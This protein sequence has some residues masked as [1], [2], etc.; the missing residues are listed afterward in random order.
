MTDI[1]I[2]IAFA[3]T[4][5]LQTFSKV[6][7]QVKHIMV[8]KVPCSRERDKIDGYKFMKLI[9]LLVIFFT[10]KGNSQQPFIRFS[11]IIGHNAKDRKGSLKKYTFSEVRKMLH[12][13]CKS[14]LLH[15]EFK[16]DTLYMLES[17]DIEDQTYYG[18]IWNRKVAVEYK[19]QQHKFTYFDQMKLFD[20]SLVE[21]VQSWD[22]TLINKESGLYG[23]TVSGRRIYATRIVV[24][25]RLKALVND[26]VFSTYLK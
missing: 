22:T 25:N 20:E 15:R 11:S 9:P 1:T 3:V 23:P 4:M 6:C 7:E 5:M 12:K 10:L 16:N 17:F 18:R 24:N 13:D 26:F 21:N 8:V 19:Y 2:L 14:P